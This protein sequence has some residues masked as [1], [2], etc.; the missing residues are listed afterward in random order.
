MKRAALGQ[1]LL[2]EQHGGR[3][4]GILREGAGGGAG[5]Q[6]KKQREVEPL[7]VMLL[8]NIA[9]HTRTLETRDI[10]D[11][12]VIQGNN[13]LGHGSGVGVRRARRFRQNHTRDS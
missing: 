10:S 9:G 3:L 8:A 1:M 4:D 11:A 2:A 12:G 13:Q 5:T 7:Q 6:G